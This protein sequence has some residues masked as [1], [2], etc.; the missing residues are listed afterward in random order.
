MPLTD[1]GW[2]ELEF[3]QA[4]INEQQLIKSWIGPNVDLSPE[5]FWGKLAIKEAHQDVLVDQ[6]GEAVYDG[7]SALQA[8][9]VSLD[10][11]GSNIG[12]ARSL[13][14]SAVANLDVTGDPGYLIAA[15]TKFTTGDGTVFLSARDVQLDSKGKG[16]LAVYSEDQAAYVNADANSITEQDEPVENIYDVTN[17]Q[18]ASGGADLE[19]DYDYRHRI[20]PNESAQEGPSRNGLKVAILNVTGVTDAQVIENKTGDVDAYGNPPY[21]VHIYVMGGQPQAVAQKILDVA[22]DGTTFVGDTVVSA[23]DDG[24]EPQEIRFDQEQLVDIKFSLSIQSNTTVDEDA[25]RQSVLDYFTNLE[26][27]QTVILNQLYSYLYQIDGVDNVESITAGTGST[28][29]T[30]NIDIKDYQ[31]AHTTDDLIEVKVHA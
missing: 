24:G 26:M 10:R 5:G 17:P 30:A 29:G 22:A 4:L 7:G 20:L 27:G 15:D 1:D 2:V 6:Q 16:Q 12:V 23:V 18:P 13:S 28:L 19:T 8:N 14:Q 25:V 21:S 11:Q 31:L 3:D 9:G